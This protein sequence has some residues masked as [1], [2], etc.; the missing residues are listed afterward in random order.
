[1]LDYQV[2]G[3]AYHE[4]GMLKQAFEAYRGACRLHGDFESHRH[5]LEATGTPDQIRVVFHEALGVATRRRP[6][7]PDTLNGFAWTL[8]T[9]P[10]GKLRDGKL[11]VEL[12]T[13]ACELTAW[14]SSACLDTLAAAHAEAGDFDTAI[15]RQNQAIALLTDA[16]EKED[17]VKRLKLYKDR[18][19]Y[20]S[21]TDPEDTGY[22]S[23]RAKHFQN[24]KPD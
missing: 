15:R 10:D 4:K 8:A 21:S 3:I 19:P 24:K 6:N 18:K 9:S 13:K 1:M 14:K 2:L 22:E 23:M 11:S 12:A 16:T 20:R 17:F 7:D 5:F